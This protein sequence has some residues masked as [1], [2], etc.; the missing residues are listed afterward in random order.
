MT[1]QL[2]LLLV[3][4]PKSGRINTGTRSLEFDMA[5]DHATPSRGVVRPGTSNRPGDL[6]SEDQLRIAEIL[7][8]RLDQHL[9]GTT[10]VVLKRS[11]IVGASRRSHPQAEV[12]METL[13]RLHCR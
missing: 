9:E 6:S 5:N 13:S 2:P 8:N 7:R 12:G 3:V 10:Q 4:S 1:Q 11:A